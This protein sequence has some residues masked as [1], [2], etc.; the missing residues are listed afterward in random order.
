MT[1]KHANLKLTIIALLRPQIHA[2]VSLVSLINIVMC[3]PNQQQS[4]TG[5]TMTLT[6][7]V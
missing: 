7:G 5:Q 6:V 3:S 2:S 1:I 4:E